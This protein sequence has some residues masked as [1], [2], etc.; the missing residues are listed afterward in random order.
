M[1]GRDEQRADATDDDEHEAEPDPCRG[2]E[3]ALDGARRWPA[4][5]RG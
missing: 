3:A 4:E 2:V 5:A 1:T